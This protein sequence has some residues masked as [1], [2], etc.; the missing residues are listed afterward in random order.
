MRVKLETI[1]IE[2]SF[3]ARLSGSAKTKFYR[4]FYGWKNFSNFGKYLYLKD[5]I[6]SNIPYLKP[7]RSTVIVPRRHAKTIREFFKKNSVVFNEKIIVL[8]KNEAKAL[9]FEFDS[10]LER[11]YEEVKGNENLHFEIDF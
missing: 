5:G 6:L 3:D 8:N 2:F 4:E 11:I 10:A 9:G 1:G 7:T